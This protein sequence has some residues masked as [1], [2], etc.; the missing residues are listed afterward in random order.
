MGSG[1]MSVYAKD[2]MTSGVVCAREDMTV[3]QL[4]QFLQ[5]HEITGAPVLDETGVLT[6][7]VSTTDII[8]QDELF[9]EGPVLESD[10]YSQIEVRG[11]DLKDDLVL[12]DLGDRRVR[13]IMSP[14]IITASQDTPME[15][16]AGIMYVH[17]IHR[18][19]IVEEGRV[20]GIVS[21]MDIL[22]AVMETK[23]P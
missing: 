13:D 19:I 17:R 22:Q 23:M 20:A 7:V 21:T 16:L 6:G 4:V 18:V 5:Q 3:Q 10:Y 8:L 1:K 12:E 9:G 11:G 15:R 14:D 2:I